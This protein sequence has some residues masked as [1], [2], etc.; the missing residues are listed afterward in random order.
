MTRCRRESKWVTRCSALAKNVEAKSELIVD[1]VECIL[2]LKSS[3]LGV[4]L[5]AQ[6]ER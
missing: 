5:L 1:K 4:T 6:D 2:S 3:V